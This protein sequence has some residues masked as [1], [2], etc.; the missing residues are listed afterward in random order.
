M[1]LGRVGETLATKRHICPREEK[2]IARCL[3]CNHLFEYIPKELEFFIRHRA[4]VLVLV[5]LIWLR[6]Q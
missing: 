6:I 5:L 1:D 3:V 2:R 4:I